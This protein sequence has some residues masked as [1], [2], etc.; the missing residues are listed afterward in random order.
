MYTLEV[1]VKSCA[2]IERL[3]KILCHS[4]LDFGVVDS[5]AACVPDVSRCDGPT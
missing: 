4:Y 2:T 1:N 3:L 5:K